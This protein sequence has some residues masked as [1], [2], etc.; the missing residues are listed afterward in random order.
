MPTALLEGTFGLIKPASVLDVGCGT[1]RSLDWFL[2]KE[3]KVYGLEG[4]RIGIKHARNPQYIKQT[5]L[6]HSVDLGRRFDLVWCFEVAEHIHPNFTENFLHT[7][8]RHGD[9]VMMSAAHPGQGGTGH[10]NEQPRSYWL[11]RFEALGF[12]HDDSGRDEIIKDWTWYPE[13]IFLFRK[14]NDH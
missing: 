7:L 9:C 1:G 12:V 13:N 8:T 6:N 4:S 5:D 3:I 11:R 2:E 10:F 14:K